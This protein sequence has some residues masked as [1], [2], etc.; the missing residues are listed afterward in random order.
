M[1][2]PLEAVQNSLDTRTLHRY[3]ATITLV[4]TYILMLLGAYTSAIGAGLS[5]PDWPTC[6]GTWIP[7]LSPGVVA[8]SPYSALQ[9]FAEWAHRGLAIIVGLLILGT[10][11][12]AWYGQRDR[13]L[14]V[15]SAVLAIALLPVQV[16]L[17]GLTVTAQLQP[18]V[19]TSHLGVAILIL[20]SLTV[21]ALVAWI[22]RRIT[23]VENTVSTRSEGA[24]RDCD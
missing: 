7:F 1:E 5:C 12:T 17:G 18:V 15:W 4:S 2:N 8:N 6:Y 19:V 13:P 20:V 16:L 3:L 9:I 21:T 14:I 10:V 24:R 11:V 23:P 22:D